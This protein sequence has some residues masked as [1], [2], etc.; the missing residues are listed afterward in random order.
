MFKKSKKEPFNVPE[1]TQNDC[2]MGNTSGKNT[3][4]TIMGILNSSTKKTSLQDYEEL[5]T[6]EELQEM[7]KKMD[8]IQKILNNYEKTFS[9]GC[10]DG[11]HPAIAHAIYGVVENKDYFL[12]E[13]QEL[14]ETNFK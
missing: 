11:V 7:K 1:R 13:Y 10:N 5:G 2:L 8:E 12:E 14:L 9:W 6:V 3:T 4:E